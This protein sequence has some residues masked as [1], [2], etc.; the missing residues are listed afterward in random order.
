[1]FFESKHKAENSTNIPAVRTWE[2]LIPPPQKY[3][4]SHPVFSTKDDAAHQ[5]EGALEADFDPRKML[6]RRSSLVVAD[7]PVR[8]L[9]SNTLAAQDGTVEEESEDEDEEDDSH[10]GK[11]KGKKEEEKEKLDEE[12]NGAKASDEVK[13]KKKPPPTQF[14]EPDANSLL[15]AF[16]F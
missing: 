10:E 12:K 13:K 4:L 3:V 7:L 9:V 14:N 1:L 8:E 16:G 5:V 6:R 2:F 11:P 15:D